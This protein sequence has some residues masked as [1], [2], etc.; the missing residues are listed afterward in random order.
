MLAV[1]KEVDAM[2]ELAGALEALLGGRLV[3]SASLAERVGYRVGGVADLLAECWSEDELSQA[4]AAAHGAGVPAFVLGRGTNLLVRDGGIRGLVLVLEGALAAYE[5]VEVRA[6]GSSI[7]KVGAGMTTGALVQRLTKDC[8]GGAEFLALIPGTM[9]GAVRMNAGAHGGEMKHILKGVRVAG[10]DGSI[11]AREARALG[12]SYR[13][14]SLAP[15]EIV[16]SMQLVLQP[17]SAQEIRS[18]VR[19]HAAYRQKTQPTNEPN[20]GSVFK[21][22]EG[23]YAGRLIEQA[24]LKGLAVGGARVSEKHANFIVTGEGASAADVE[25]LAEK[26]RAAVEEKFGVSLELE[27]KIVGESLN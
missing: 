16:V 14:S 15:E 19:E 26:M 12:L 7:V 10:P 2:E 20:A 21:N 4:L 11:E 9:G 8:L 17:S 1:S 25:A 5:R 18:I 3:R 13:S 22:P 23:D 24:G 6:D 27:I